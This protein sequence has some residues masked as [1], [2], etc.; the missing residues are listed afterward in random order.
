MEP[1]Q[2]STETVSQPSSLPPYD[3]KQEAAD[4]VRALIERDDHQAAVEVLGHMYTETKDCA[5]P[6]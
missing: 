5:W 3:D 1:P 6:S 4:R 2:D